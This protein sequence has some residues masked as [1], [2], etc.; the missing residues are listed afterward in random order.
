MHAHT[1]ESTDTAFLTTI[2]EVAHS[3]QETSSQTSGREEV[4]NARA[5]LKHDERFST[6]EFA[7]NPLHYMERER[8]A[9]A[10]FLGERFSQVLQNEGR[11][12]SFGESY[13]R[14]IAPLEI[15]LSAIEMRSALRSQEKSHSLKSSEDVNEA[16]IV[17]S[18]AVSLLTL[19]GVD[20]SFYEE[21]NMPVPASVLNAG[22]QLMG[23]LVEL[24]LNR[25]D[26]FEEAVNS[27]MMFNERRA[28]FLV[29][30]LPPKYRAKT[31]TLVSRYNELLE[32]RAVG[33][34]AEIVAGFMMGEVAAELGLDIQ[35]APPHIDDAGV[36][37]LSYEG[38]LITHG[39]EVKSSPRSVNPKQTMQLATYLVD[40][41]VVL[42]ENL[43]GRRMEVFQTYLRFLSKSGVLGVSI[44][45]PRSFVD[46]TMGVR[47]NPND[48]RG[49]PSTIVDLEGIAAGR[50]G[51]HAQ[52]ESIEGFKKHIGELLQ[53]TNE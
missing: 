33:V 37:F 15:G 20:S 16:L 42:S 43:M 6:P 13:F 28:Q 14:H 24:G 52:K 29:E 12:M 26:L 8:A 11:S 4:N 45:V 21:F 32:S 48:M 53:P 31:E 10:K 3:T 38:D 34:R 36:D 7:N 39:I 23:E 1:A 35:K 49:H 46:K 51:S 27:S 5:Y 44:R 40:N 30:N 41:D 25:P 18:A 2:S 19:V 22:T 47:H 50:Y 17:H 9:V